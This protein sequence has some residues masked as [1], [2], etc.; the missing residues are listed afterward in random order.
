MNT[1]SRITSIIKANNLDHSITGLQTF[2]LSELNLT[3]TQNFQL[4]SNIR[5]GHLVEKI[6]SELIKSSTNYNMIYENIYRPKINVRDGSVTFILNDH[7]DYIRNLVNQKYAG[8]SLFYNIGNCYF[9]LEKFGM[10]IADEAKE[11]ACAVARDVDLILKGLPDILNR[12]IGFLDEIINSKKKGGKLKADKGINIPNSNLGIR[13]LTKKDQVDLQFIAKNADAVNFSF[14][15]NKHDVEELQTALKK[16]N[17]EIGIILKIETQEAFKNLP[18]IILK[19]M[20]NYPI[21]VMIAR[22][23]ESS[24]LKIESV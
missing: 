2:D 5:L 24:L 19:A 16:L 18:S 12:I 17:T 15:N 1:K 13:G 20:E 10:A 21:G 11:N 14:V 6:V 8:T 23:E 3:N 4:P 9:K 7:M 22:G